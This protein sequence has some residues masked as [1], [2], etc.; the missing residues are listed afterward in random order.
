MHTRIQRASLATLLIS[1][2]FSFSAI[3]AQSAGNSGTIYG[4]A[5]TAC[6]RNL[7]K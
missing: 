7:L 1:I 4:T 5:N 2:S 3:L 6:Q